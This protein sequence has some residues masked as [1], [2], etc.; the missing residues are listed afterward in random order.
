MRACP[1]R[2]SDFIFVKFLF[3]L[4]QSFAY[5]PK[6]L[7]PLKHDNQILFFNDSK[8]FLNSPITVIFK[9]VLKNT[10]IYVEQKAIKV[11]NKTNCIGKIRKE[12]HNAE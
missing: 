3:F 8:N 9:I 7:T 6:R 5:H 12:I 2:V 11:Y 4:S 10:K 1:I